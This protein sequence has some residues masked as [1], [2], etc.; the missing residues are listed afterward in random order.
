MQQVSVPAPWKGADVLMTQ[1]WMPVQGGAADQG[2]D[3]QVWLQWFACSRAGCDL[4]GVHTQRNT[5]GRHLYKLV[6]T[7]PG[8]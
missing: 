2:C 1:H 7:S 3:E 8:R 5:R 6:K 4:A